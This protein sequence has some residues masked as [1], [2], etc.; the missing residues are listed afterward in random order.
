M[1]NDKMDAII[2]AV[3]Q[4]NVEG[5]VGGMVTF[6]TQGERKLKGGRRQHHWEDWREYHTQDPAER[7]YGDFLHLTDKVRVK[8][9]MKLIKF[10]FFQTSFLG[11]QPGTVTNEVAV[12]AI[13]SSW[14]SQTRNVTDSKKLFLH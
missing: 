5:G 9:H 7:D 8:L 12:V 10:F 14:T 11:E 13:S 3:R 6:E 2:A 1:M 4:F